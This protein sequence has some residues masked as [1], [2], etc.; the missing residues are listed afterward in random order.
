MMPE[1]PF[2]RTSVLRDFRRRMPPDTPIKD[3]PGRSVSQTPFSKILYR[4]KHF[5]VTYRSRVLWQSH[6]TMQTYEQ[7]RNP[8][9]MAYR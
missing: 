1:I 3:R 9:K 5:M 4:P 7:P 2:S 8:E 6:A